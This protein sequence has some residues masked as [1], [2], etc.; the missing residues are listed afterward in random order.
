MAT[1]SG[2]QT[3]SRTHAAQDASHPTCQQGPEHA[4]R[5]G[6]GQPAGRSGAAAR[7]GA[8]AQ[9]RLERPHVRHARPRLLDRV[10]RRLERKPLAH[11]EAGDGRRGAAG[12]PSGGSCA[13]DPSIDTPP[14]TACARAP[15]GDKEGGVFA[16]A[17]SDEERLIQ[18]TARR[19]A[20][21]RLLPGLRAHERARGVPRELVGEFAA[22]GLTAGEDLG[23][24]ARV[25]V[26]EELAAVDAGAALALDAGGLAQPLLDAAGLGA[27]R[28][29]GVVIEDVEGRF[30]ARDGRLA[31]EH[32][33]VPADEIA[34]AVVLHP[35]R[36]LIV[37]EGWRLTPIAACGLEAAGASR[38]VLD[39]APIA[40]TLEDPRA[41]GRARAGIRTAV[42]AL[43]VGAARGTHEYA[44]RYATERTAFGRPIAHHQALAFLIADLATAVD[45]ARLAVWRAAAALDRGESAEWEGASALAEAAE[46]ALFVG[47][48]AVQILGG[49]GFMKDHPVEKSMRDI[50][51]L[52]QMA[53]GRDE[54]ELAAA[55]LVPERELGFARRGDR[56]P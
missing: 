39:D 11:V 47:P 12:G 49:H 37:R 14:T 44:M 21:D 25:L 41:L 24:F 7:L 1:E 6:R 20:R 5:R 38:L 52:A 16:L 2:L 13:G 34:V 22:L 51:T 33:W 18:D 26:L 29:R 55:A 15:R 19:F 32:P 45:I 23:A 3:P 43:L 31:G 35:E 10:A 4:P 53:G 42:G 28:G 50:R 9:V 40:A 36:A 48:N 54:A 17:L 56:C 27:A 30:H 8:L 46:Q